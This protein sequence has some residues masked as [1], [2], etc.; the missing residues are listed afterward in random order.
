MEKN[1]TVPAKTKKGGINPVITIVILYLIAAAI[2]YFIF[3]NPNNFE[4]GDVDKGHPHNFLGII[5]KGGHIIPFLMSFF[6]MVIVFSIDRVIALNKAKGTGS[7]EKFVND[8]RALLNKNEV[9]KAIELCDKQKGAVGNVV[10]EGLTTY[11]A[12]ENDTTLNKEQKLA[13]LGKTLEEATTLEMPTLEKNM[14]IISTIA[15]VGTLIALMGTVIG[16]IKAFFALGEG[17]GSPDAAQLS[18]G[19]AEALINT[20]MGIGASAFAIIMYAFLTSKIDD[21]TFKIDEVGMS[22]QQSFSAHN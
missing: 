13:Q 12:L 10:K 19:I 17:G 5:R 4:N 22:I 8:I 14:T 20:G 1:V 3:G 2:F 11:K 6:F 16:M 7:A 21:L 9:N 18:V 15:S